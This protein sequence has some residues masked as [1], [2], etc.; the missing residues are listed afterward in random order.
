MIPA[1]RVVKADVS[2]CYLKYLTLKEE[3]LKFKAQP[4]KN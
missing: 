4:I 3:I 1:V 2:L